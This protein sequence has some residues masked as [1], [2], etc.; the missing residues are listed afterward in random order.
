MLSG[1]T[2]LGCGA[3]LNIVVDNFIVGGGVGMDNLLSSNISC[4]SM[5]IS[6]WEFIQGGCIYE[7][8]D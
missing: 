2:I 3:C 4:G 8:N 1:N 6:N 5:S 7:F